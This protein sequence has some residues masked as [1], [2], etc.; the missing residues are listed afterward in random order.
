MQINGPKISPFFSVQDQRKWHVKTF[1]LVIQYFSAYKQVQTI[2]SYI[3][4]KTLQF[5]LLQDLCHKKLPL[6][7]ISLSCT[8]RMCLYL[9][10]QSFWRLCWNS[11]GKNPDQT[12]V[13]DVR[14]PPDPVMDH[15]SPSLGHTYIPS[16][17]KGGPHISL[18]IAS[19]YI[20]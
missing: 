19:S 13:S 16:V 20:Q 14:P 18:C 1:E 11:C 2:Y 7:Q 9:D 8:R 17:T 3:F 12:S 4:T 6:G 15:A 5:S 10:F